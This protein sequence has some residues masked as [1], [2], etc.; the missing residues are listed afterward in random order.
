M[1]STQQAVVYDCDAERAS[2]VG[3]LLKQLGYQP[4]VIDHSALVRTVL[5]ASSGEQVLMIGDV[6]DA[7]DWAELGT[8]LRGPLC[9]VQVI[10]YGSPYVADELGAATGAQRVLRLRFPFDADSL[11]AALHVPL[12]QS[13]QDT[14]HVS[15]P[16][17]TSPAVREVNRLI[18]QVAAHG[19]SV[20]ILG[21]SGTGKELV[22]HAIHDAS[23]RRQRPFVAINCGAIPSELLE[24]ELF[25][26]EKGS[27]T[28]AVSARKGRFEIAEGGT[29]FL[30]EIGDMSMTMQ[31]KLLRV[32]QERVF[33]RVG[34]H[35]PIR[36]NVR[37]IAA[38]HRNLEES[39]SKGS[40][41]EDLFYRLNVFPIEMPPL[42]ARVEDLPMLVRDFAAMN[43]ANG[44]AR[45]QLQPRVMDALMNYSWPGNVRELGNLIERLSILCPQGRVEVSDLPARYR[46][47]DW[48]P[49]QEAQLIFG[50]LQSPVQQSDELPESAAMTEATAAS[51]EDEGVLPDEQALLIMAGDHG[52]DGSL[53]ELPVHGLDLR[54]HLYDIERALIRQ[55]MDRAGGTVA[56]AAR[57][58]Q[59]RRTTLVEKLR[60]FEM[61]DDRVASEV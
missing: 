8:V 58:L 29:L 28:G 53:A 1:S 3:L 40:F 42:R 20:L 60:K 19:S 7:P 48:T 46:P 6:S 52:S 16:T 9:D 17:G 44:R 32:L 34:S 36:C 51:H 57:L 30:D 39:I 26:H 49:D 24:S 31:V 5:Q 33:E 4:M 45:I 56:H 37:I 21:E 22:A 43:A 15:M 2:Q 47:K 14:G 12:V 41:R 23:P 55:A 10:S 11:A 61:I 50:S 25:G 38:T 54:S 13:E 27:F 35:S 18:K 59:L